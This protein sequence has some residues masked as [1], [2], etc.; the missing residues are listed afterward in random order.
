VNHI[1]TQPFVKQQYS[2]PTMLAD[3][4]SDPFVRRF[5]GFGT[6]TASDVTSWR[7]GKLRSLEGR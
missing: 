6:E 4:V 3:R 1:I 2:F 7:R 5:L